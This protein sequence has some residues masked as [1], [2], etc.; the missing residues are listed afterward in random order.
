MK[1]RSGKTLIVNKIEFRPDKDNA[2]RLKRVF[3]LLLSSNRLH[4]EDTGHDEKE[5]HL[6]E[7]TGMNQG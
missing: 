1:H 4:E 5:L 2:T 7:D 3:A 6:K